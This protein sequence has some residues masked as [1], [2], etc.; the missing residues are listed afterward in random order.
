MQLAILL[1]GIILNMPFVPIT[2]ILN[3]I[4][5]LSSVAQIILILFIQ[6]W[7]DLHASRSFKSLSEEY[8]IQNRKKRAV[9]LRCST[10]QKNNYLISSLIH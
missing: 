5:A 6:V 1:A 7:I 10:F 8:R 9:S 2:Q 4:R 3:S